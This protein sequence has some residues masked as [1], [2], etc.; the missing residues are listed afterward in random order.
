MHTQGASFGLRAIAA[1]KAAKGLLV[2]MAGSG[3]LL[4]VHRDVQGLA[5][6]LV[7]HFNLNPAS[8]Y[9]RIF[10]EMA[11]RAT[12]AHLRLMAFGA[13][14]Y[15]ALQ[16]VEGAGLWHARRWAE[17][18]SVFT[19]LIYVPFEA[20]ALANKPG[21]QPLAALIANL[22]IVMFL[23]VQLRVSTRQ[24]SLFDR[25]RRGRTIVQTRPQ[26]RPRPRRRRHQEDSDLPD[27]SAHT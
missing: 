15:A 22:A 16:C 20:L 5:E 25:P 14:C 19:G 9:P 13:F 4:L 23:V 6:Q 10:L 24:W 18:L 8:R 7:A 1:F 26:S 21:W 12:P 11:T 3:A 2:L 17:W 27:R